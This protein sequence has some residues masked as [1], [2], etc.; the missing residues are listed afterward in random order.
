MDKASKKKVGLQLNA[1]LNRLMSKSESSLICALEDSRATTTYSTV[2]GN[3]HHKQPKALPLIPSPVLRPLT[4]NSPRLL[5]NQHETGRPFI[6][7]TVN[8]LTA[9]QS[10]S[11]LLPKFSLDSRK[12]E[13]HAQRQ[14]K[15]T[16][17]PT[18]V[19]TKVHCAGPTKWRPDLS[20]KIDVLAIV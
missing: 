20:L 7:P 19:E 1:G 5:V 13:I 15:I 8:A 2:N 10:K 9:M 6:I 16:I 12:E 11:P 18:E 3:S 4:P 14:P 17:Q